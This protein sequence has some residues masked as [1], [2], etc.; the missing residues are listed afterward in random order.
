M[1][2]TKDLFTAKRAA[3]TIG[4]VVAIVAPSMALHSL[5]A[6]G[7]STNVAVEPPAGAT[8]PTTSTSTSVPSAGVAGAGSSTPFGSTAAAAT[9]TAT[10]ATTATVTAAPPSTVAV[11][12]ATTTPPPPPPVVTT[13]PPPPSGPGSPLSY[14]FANYTKTNA[15]KSPIRW[16]PSATVHYLVNPANA[17]AGAA[18]DLT[19]AF[20]E[21][22]AATGLNFVNDGPTGWSPW[23]AANCP[24]VTCWNT[25]GQ[26]TGIDGFPPVLIGW[27]P[28]SAPI[29]VTG[30][31]GGT[32]AQTF[33]E[34]QPTVWPRGGDFEL[35]SGIL[36]FNSTVNLPGGF[37]GSSRGVVM[38]HELG[39]LVGLASVADQDQM[40]YSSLDGHVAAYG[41]GDLAGLKIAG[42]GVTYRLQPRQ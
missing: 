23:D 30:T 28:A 29:L 22:H 8:A 38:L 1:P 42:Q 17:P 13:V 37:G 19:Q 31:T 14:A 10:P 5:I 40:M 6:K 9:A 3:I 27:V 25:H 16:S 12:P 18:A 7:T 11:A 32:L 21:L 35:V 41:A 39:L 36:A 20:V 15:D 24:S 34:L 4:V 2:N 26:R 33:V